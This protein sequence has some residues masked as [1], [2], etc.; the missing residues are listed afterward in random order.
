MD[1]T[2]ILAWDQAGLAL[3]HAA[4]APW[5]DS[6][7]VV[8]TW[9]GSLAL[10][11]PL[12]LL[13]WWRWR[14]ARSAAFV[15]LALVGASALGHLAKLIAARPRPDLFPPLI[16][17][18]EDWSFPSA[19]AVQV[20]AFALAWLLRPGAAPGRIEIAV[21]LAAVTVVIASR[22][23]LQVHFPSDVIAGAL[24]A[25]LWVVFLRRLPIWRTNNHQD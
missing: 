10:L 6:L 25:I 24:L 16:A 23:Y 8:V 12:A 22:L 7:F 1:P 21:L 2:R 17:M 14:G 18:P 11:L 5:L 20:T 19:H 9:F 4:R 3:A 13:A 15:A